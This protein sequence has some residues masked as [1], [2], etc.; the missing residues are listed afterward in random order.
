MNIESANAIVFPAANRKNNTRAVYPSEINLT[1]IIKSVTDQDSFLIDATKKENND[2]E[3]SSIELIIGG[4]YF[5]LTDLDFSNY[6][7]DIYFYIKVN[8]D[9]EFPSLSPISGESL[10]GLVDNV[11]YFYG[12]GIENSVEGSGATSYLKFGKKTNVGVEIDPNAYFKFN[13][14]SLFYTTSI[15]GI[16]TDVNFPRITS[17][18]YTGNNTEPEDAKNGD[19]W[20]L[21]E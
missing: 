6:S 15:N 16:S 20:I 18:K 21:Y 8:D 10:D 2:N 14:R 1:N 13:L 11:N 19:I 7:G 9:G 12:I 5:K 17:E 4:Y 3:F